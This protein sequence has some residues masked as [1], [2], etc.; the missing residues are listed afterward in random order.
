MEAI[1]DEHE[2]LLPMLRD[3]L[4]SGR[5]FV[6][7]YDVDKE[8]ESGSAIRAARIDTVSKIVEALEV[9]NGLGR[10]ARTPE[11]L[12]S[13]TAARVSAELR[14]QKRS[15]VMSSKITPTTSAYIE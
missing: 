12:K 4:D 2:T 14:F 6:D 13:I 5:F 15:I 3:A 9:Y 10:E 1:K 8:E 11:V 7:S